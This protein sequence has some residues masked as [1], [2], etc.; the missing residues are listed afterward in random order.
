MNY[1]K[2]LRKILLIKIMT[3]ST[4]LLVSSCKKPH[5]DLINDIRDKV[6]VAYASARLGFIDSSASSLCSGQPSKIKWNYDFSIGVGK[7]D[8]TYH[9]WLNSFDRFYKMYSV[10]FSTAGG[11]SEKLNCEDLTFSLTPGV[12]DFTGKFSPSSPIEQ[13]GVL[14]SDCSV[15]LSKSLKVGP[16]PGV[17]ALTYG[18]KISLTHSPIIHSATGAIMTFGWEY[19]YACN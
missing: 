9:K 12:I 16:V 7:Y 2:N 4:V 14:N 5:E 11:T 13:I 6:E 1:I 17:A 19:T 10:A 15:T 18:Y 3:L 8:Y